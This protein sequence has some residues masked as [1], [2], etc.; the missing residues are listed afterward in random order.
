VRANI[1][2]LLGTQVLEAFRQLVAVESF[3]KQASAP[4]KQQLDFDLR[5]AEC[6]NGRGT[7]Q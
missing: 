7:L 2:L 5:D 3:A 6:F 1:L 4:A